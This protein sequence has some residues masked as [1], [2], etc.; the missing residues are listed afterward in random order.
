MKSLMQKYKTQ[1]MWVA[2]GVLLVLGL[3]AAKELLLG[4][5]GVLAYL[6]KPAP[7][8]PVQKVDKAMKDKEEQDK[9]IAES[10]AATVEAKTKAGKD[11]AQEIDDFLNGD[12]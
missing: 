12:F 1:I 3:F 10:E 5:V 9:V 7:L 11:K 8:S 2:I 4:V 6:F